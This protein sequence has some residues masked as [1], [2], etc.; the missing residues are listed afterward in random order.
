[1][2][3]SDS[4]TANSL[5]NTLTEYISEIIVLILRF[6][7]R[8]IFIKTLGQSYLGING[9]FSDILTLLS[10]TELGFGTAIIFK[11]YKPI[12]EN[13]KHRI[14]LLMKFYK[15]V[16]QIIGWV[17][18]L[19]GIAL[20]PLLPVVINNYDSLASKG[21]NA[22]LIFLIYLFQSA[23]SYWFFAYKKSIVTAHQKGYK[24]NTIGYGFTVASSLLQIAVLCILPHT[25][26]EEKGLSF[27]VYT[28]VAIVIIIIQ[29]IVNAV[30]S[31]RMY[32]YIN[33]K[34]KD[35][36]SKAEMK[37]LFKDCY[38]LFLYKINSVVIRSTD[39]VILTYFIGL[40]I[41]GLYSNYILML[42]TFKNFILKFMNGINASLGSLHASGK[43]EYEEKILRVINY[44]SF[45]IFGIAA[46]GT[47][48]IGDE[49]IGV[50]VGKEYVVNSFTAIDGAWFLGGKTFVTPVAIL[51]A[52]EIY[53]YGIKIFLAK[54]RE[55]MGLFQQSKYRPVAS[56]IV[57][58]CV[59]LAL[60]PTFGIAGAVTGT[61][62]AD[63]TTT[64]WYDPRVIY[65]VGLKQK[66]ANRFFKTNFYYL[67]LTAVS[68]LA[69]WGLCSV[70]NISFG[71]IS[72]I[73]HA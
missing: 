18:M 2:S 73:V 41:V 38:A 40:D 70:V 32:P 8:S 68:A 17:I 54:Y 20:I 37:E 33:E 60:V 43:S 59:S 42:T 6:V 9:Y 22:V 29:N 52:I 1:M 51:V 57:N 28:V 26:A 48:V 24:L 63:I 19:L 62:V 4:R 36:I 55:T 67:G 27:I 25:S 69:S 10:L 64:L 5:K 11:L 13:D 58:L 16:Y 71:W 65:R 72:V 30:I 14:V 15:R 53:C 49:F 39:S 44:L 21:I 34:T 7:T 45:W 31:D 56:M 12:E 50:W 3:K 61:I 35:K 47:A 66:N 46:V 23:S